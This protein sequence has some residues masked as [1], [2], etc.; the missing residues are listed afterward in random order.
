MSASGD[1]WEPS[2]CCG[3]TLTLSQELTSVHQCP[4]PS[5]IMVIPSAL[6]VIRG[7]LNY[8]VKTDETVLKIAL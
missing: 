3:W 8:S 5:K 7:E 1:I 6:I 2:S 4:F